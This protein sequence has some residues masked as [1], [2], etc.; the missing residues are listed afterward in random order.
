MNLL[1]AMT[2]RLNRLSAEAQAHLAKTMKEAELRD[3]Y[4]VPLARILGYLVYWTW[5]SKHSPKGFPDVFLAHPVTGA[6]I[7]RELK[8]VGGGKKYQPT[9]AQQAWLAAFGVAGL[10][11]AVWTPAD[12]ISGRIERELRA[13]AART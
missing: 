1:D 3:D 12:M 6:I 9:E 8:R 13:G 11:A 10:D 7:I 2:S 4:I 5:N